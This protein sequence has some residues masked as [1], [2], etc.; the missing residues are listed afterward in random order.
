M[1]TTK[2][3]AKATNVKNKVHLFTTVFFDKKYY[4]NQEFFTFDGIFD[5]AN[6]L[7]KLFRKVIV[8]IGKGA[9]L[10]NK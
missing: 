5:G 7:N 1:E 10:N 6:T 2:T 4:W 8:K 9:I 3:G